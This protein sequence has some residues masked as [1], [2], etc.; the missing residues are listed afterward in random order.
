[1]VQ[2]LTFYEI[3]WILKMSFKHSL[4]NEILLIWLKRALTIVK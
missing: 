1:V 3:R 2:D 4:M